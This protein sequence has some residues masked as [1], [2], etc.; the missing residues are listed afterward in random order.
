MKAPKQRR[1][2]YQVLINSIVLPVVLGIDEIFFGGI[3]RKTHSRKQYRCVLGDVTGL[4]FVAVLLVRKLAY[5]SRF[6]SNIPE[7]ERRVVQVIAIDMWRPF[8]LLA[9]SVFPWTRIV[10]DKFHVVRIANDCVAAVRLAEQN[11]I[12]PTAIATATLGLVRCAQPGM[13]DLLIES[14]F[15]WRRAFRAYFALATFV[16]V[17]SNV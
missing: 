10:I 1:D 15:L 4:K 5:V 17:R 16:T 11:K 12:V 14:R 8:K 3:Q 2:L 9:E 13:L 7:A 6:L